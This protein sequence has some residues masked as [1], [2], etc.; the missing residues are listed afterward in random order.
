MVP[1]LRELIAWETFSILIRI[2]LESLGSVESTEKATLFPAWRKRRREL[3][4]ELTEQV[5]LN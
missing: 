1:A 3:F 2:R 5:C 4:P